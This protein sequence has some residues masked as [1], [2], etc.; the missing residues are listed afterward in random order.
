M[1]YIGNFLFEMYHDWMQMLYKAGLYIM[2][3]VL[4]TTIDD[5]LGEI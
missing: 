1:G 5:F 4:F 3:F 2:I